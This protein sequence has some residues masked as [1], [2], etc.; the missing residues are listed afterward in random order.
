[1]H[2]IDVFKVSP[3]AAN[4]SQLPIQRDWMDE[5]FDKHA[6]K[7]FP[8]SLTNGLGWGISFPKDIVFIWDGINTSDPR[9]EHV[10]I[11]EGQEYAYSQ[12]ANATVSFNTGLVFRTENNLSILHMPVPNQFIEGYHAFTTLI[13]TSFFKGAMPSAARITKSNKEIIIKANTPVAAILP[14]SLTQLNNSEINM[15]SITD[16]PN[17]FFPGV[18]YNDTV[19]KINKEGKWT[20]FY[21]DAVDHKGNKIG[22]HEIKAIRLKV[23][24]GNPVMCDD[25]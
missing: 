25:K 20:N 9:E 8:V 22:E 17:N 15:K 5:T 1:M 10:K 3:N 21:R 11:L 4:I 14:I 13:S 2:S 16:L 23:N 12:R 7:C 18:D 24:D 19:S 6:Y